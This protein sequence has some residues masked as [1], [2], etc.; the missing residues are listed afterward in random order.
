MSPA[1]VWLHATAAYLSDSPIVEWMVAVVACGYVL[2]YAYVLGNL[3]STEDATYHAIF[4]VK[5]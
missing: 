1:Q 5:C 3:R 4:Q 2:L